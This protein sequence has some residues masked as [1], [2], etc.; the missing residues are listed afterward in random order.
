M[1]GSFKRPS[2]LLFLSLIFTQNSM[3]PTADTAPVF[4]A[5][6]VMH[7]SS[8]RLCFTSACALLDVGSS[9]KPHSVPGMQ[10]ALRRALPGQK[11][12]GLVQAAIHKDAQAD[13]ECLK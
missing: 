4:K 3:Q 5:M 9:S 8:L 12:G 6:A 10:A 13:L 7:C 1:A 11:P 2:V